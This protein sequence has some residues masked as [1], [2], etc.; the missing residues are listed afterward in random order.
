MI[1]PRRQYARRAEY[2]RPVQ[3][4]PISSGWAILI[5]TRRQ[6]F[7]IVTVGQSAAFCRELF[8]MS[9]LSISRAGALSYH[10]AHDMNTTATPDR[11]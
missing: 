2:L 7:P 6:Y 10:S 3:V 8:F 1:L 9:R 11:A 4:G 5:A